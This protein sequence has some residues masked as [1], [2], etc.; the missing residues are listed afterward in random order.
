MAIRNTEPLVKLLF[1]RERIICLYNG[2]LVKIRKKYIKPKERLN[3]MIYMVAFILSLLALER[4]LENV[5]TS[6]SL[7]A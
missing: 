4:S 6:K 7:M 1:I 2:Q 3:R 5:K